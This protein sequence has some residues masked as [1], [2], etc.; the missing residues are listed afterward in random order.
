MKQFG[1][2]ITDEVGLHAR[3]A[4]LLQRKQRDERRR[5]DSDG[6]LQRNGR[7]KT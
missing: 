5:R 6:I 1:N 2:V 7:C 4:G 3:P